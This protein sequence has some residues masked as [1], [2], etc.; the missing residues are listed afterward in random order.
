ML[1]D[2]VDTKGHLFGTSIA[3]LENAVKNVEQNLAWS[4]KYL[5]SLFQYLD[6]RNSAVTL[7]G[8]SLLMPLLLFVLF[9]KIW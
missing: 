7:Q 4:E 5:G 6:E 8:M 3:T 9:N 1:Q 2:F